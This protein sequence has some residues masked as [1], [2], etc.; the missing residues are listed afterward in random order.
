MTLPLLKYR[1]GQFTAE[2][3]PEAGLTIRDRIELVKLGND[4][5]IVSCIRLTSN[6]IGATYYRYS[7][8]L[9]LPVHFEIEDLR[10]IN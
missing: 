3:N 1:D 9:D 10:R 4:N 2:T 5:L 8:I 6:I 7:K